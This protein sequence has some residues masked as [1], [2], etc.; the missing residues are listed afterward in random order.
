MIVPSRTGLCELPQVLVPT[1]TPDICIIDSCGHYLRYDFLFL[2][3]RCT[4]DPI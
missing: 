2:P 1:Y 4:N 3:F